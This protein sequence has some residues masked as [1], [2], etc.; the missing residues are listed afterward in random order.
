VALFTIKIRA[1]AEPKVPELDED[2]VKSMGIASG[3]VQQLRDDVRKNLAREVSNRC[4]TKTK[5]SVMEAL[6][7]FA[8]FD[9]PKA[10][11]ENES[12]RLADSTRED[13]AARG[14]NMKDV[15]I[16]ADLFTEQATKRVRLG[17]LVGEIVKAKNLQ[18]TEP[19][20]RAFVE[21]MASAY[22]KP[23]EFVAW[24][25]GQPKQR[26]E[27]EAVVIEDN[28]VNWALAAAKVVETPVTVEDLMNE[29]SGQA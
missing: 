8:T 7:Q 13:M 11:V 1:V 23:Q 15:P 10:L 24:F 19:Q 6:G 9:I 22:E 4:K 16:P 3:D 21:D 20:V 2:F 29:G 14:M 18:A 12:Q 27:A 25:M 28:V 17:L 26:A 5:T